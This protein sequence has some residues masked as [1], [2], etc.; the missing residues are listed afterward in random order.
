MDTL[1]SL[2]DGL[3]RYLA[4]WAR[5][6]LA[7]RDP[8]APMGVRRGVF[9]VLAMPLFLAVQLIHALCLLL[10]E[11]LF[12][13][14]RRIDLDDA[15][16]VTGI[17]RSGTTFLHRALALD[18]ERYTTLT[19]WQA[20]LA[21]SITQRRVVAVLARADRALGSPGRRGLDAV[22]RRLGGGLDAVHEIAVD[23][24]EEDYLALLP[25][26]GCLVM[27]LAFPSAPGLQLLAHLDARMPA[28][29][30]RRLLRFHRRCLQRHLHVDGARRILLSKNAAFGSWIRGLHEAYPGARFLVCVREPQ[31]AL[32]SQISAVGDARTLFGTAVDGA[33][34]Q[35]LFLDMFA[36]TLAH[37]A[38]TVGTWPLHRAAI[39]DTGDL[40]A[41][42]ADVIRG[43]LQRVGMDPGPALCEHLD[44]L[45]RG[46]RS[47]HRH[48]VG[49][50]AIDREQLE[51]RM[52]PAYRQLLELPHRIRPGS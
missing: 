25:A 50:L 19:T 28:G 45:P 22:S 48:D 10:D 12:P 4:W 49:A 44:A 27:L 15:L 8:R 9:L 16:F 7:W 24:A 26:G 11:I 23:A 43:A 1:A 30:R 47:A 46:T 3:G 6:L 38:E 13:R 52:G 2:V 33:P 29:R 40:A 18:A 31:A 32:S 51:R 41:A 36:A 21:P 14:Y 34:F 42:P 17:P 5:A 35:T 39:I 20:L 37:L